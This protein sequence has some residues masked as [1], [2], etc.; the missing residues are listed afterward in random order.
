[1]I[2]KE[3]YWYLDHQD[4]LVKKYNGKYIVVKDKDV[5]GS[6]NSTLD[7]YI[8][9]KKK[10]EPGTFLIQLC[11]PGEKDYTATFHSRIKAA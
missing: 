1:M 8:E 9:S 2:D 6:Y 11:T 3:F 10:F 4:E 5:V 7:A